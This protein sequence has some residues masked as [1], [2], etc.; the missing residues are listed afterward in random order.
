MDDY[1]NEFYPE[2][3]PEEKEI[4]DPEPIYNRHYI[5]TDAQGRITEGWS[6]GPHPGRD[7][8]GA[9][10]IQDEKLAQL[11]AVCAAGRGQDI[12]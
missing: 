3:P 1:L 9:V 8:S 11:S 12:G 6:D 10:D 7:T 2:T 4:P 5:I